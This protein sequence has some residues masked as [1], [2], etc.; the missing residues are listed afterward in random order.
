M[1]RIL[2]QLDGISRSKDKS[3][4]D[5]FVRKVLIK[6]RDDFEEL[7]LRVS[8]GNISEL[9]ALKKS[10]IRVFLQKFDIFVKSLNQLPK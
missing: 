10:S 1:E 9:E 2:A 8:D 7:L 6:N 4:E 3:I 5:L